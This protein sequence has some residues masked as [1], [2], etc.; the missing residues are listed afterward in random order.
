M[1]TVVLFLEQGCNVDALTSL[2]TETAEAQQLVY[3]WTKTTGKEADVTWYTTSAAYR[4]TKDFK[5]PLNPMRGYMGEGSSETIVEDGSGQV[6]LGEQVEGSAP[7][8]YDLIYVLDAAYHFPPSIGYFAATTFPVLREGGGVL[9]YTDVIPP[10]SLSR[11]PMM[12]LGG[13]MAPFLGTPVANL[14][15]RPATLDEYKAT[16]ERIG[17]TDVKIEDWTSNVFKPLADNV[18]KKGGFWAMYAKVL[19]LVDSSGWKFVA[20]RGVRPQ[21]SR[22]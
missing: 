6:V 16:L 2:A 21:G 10:P 19:R 15:R 20:V 18:E 1:L 14:N 9:A 8:P 3:N 5:H 17:F 13:M 11:F 22:K 4:P 7:G 12:L